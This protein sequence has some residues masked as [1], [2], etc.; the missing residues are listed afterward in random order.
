MSGVMTLRIAVAQI[1]PT[2]G[3]LVGNASLMV[4]REKAAKNLG[5]DITVFPELAICGYPPEDLLSRPNFIRKTGEVVRG[6]ATDTSG[7]VTIIGVPVSDKTLGNCAVVIS[8]GDIAGNVYKHEL[9]NYGVFDERRYFTPGANGPLIKIGDSLLGITVCEDIWGKN[10]IVQKQIDGGANVLVNISASPYRTGIFEERLAIARR[11]AK[12]YKVPLV[13]CNLVGGQDELVFDGRSFIC[14]QEGELLGV[15][16]AFEEDLLV[17]D[18]LPGR[19]NRISDHVIIDT[20]K[21]NVNKRPIQTKERRHTDDINEEIYTALTLAVRD[22]VGKNRFTDVVIAESGGIDSALTTAIAVDALGP[23]KVHVVAM[24]SPYS[25]K[26]S[27]D[28]TKQLAKNFGLDLLTLPIEEIMNS[29]DTT[30]SNP[31]SG[32]E[33]DIAEENI[34]ARIRGALVMALS[35]KFGWLTLTTGNKSEV[36]VGYCT[37]YGDMAGG[38]AVIKDLLKTVVYSLCEWRNKKE[39]CDIIPREIINKAP[40][41]ELREDQKDSDS[42]PPYDILDPILLEYIENNRNVDEITKLGYDRGIVLQIVRLVDLAEHKRRQG[43]IG[44]KISGKAFGRDRR[45]PITCGY[46]DN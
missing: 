41:A 23:S 44:V 25:S 16:T 37:L 45:H 2:V 12:R 5:A 40:S 15:A 19:A 27:I 14:G 31:F 22:Y 28:D 8:K 29:F 24:P 13:Y 36:A 26:G 10:D 46:F 20:G 3:D 33:K 34:Q 1:N 42:L 7:A 43:P 35:N 39:G 30:L 17:M 9:P 32:L 21:G 11:L 6:I 38:F 18:I 4:D